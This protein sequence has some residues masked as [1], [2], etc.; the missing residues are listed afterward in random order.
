MEQTSTGEMRQDVLTGRWVIYAPDRSGRP[1]EMSP[2]AAES[3]ALP[4]KDATCPFCLGNETMIPP[5]VFELASAGDHGWRT[6][7]VPNKYPVLRPDANVA[8]VHRG[9]HRVTSSYGRHEVVIET[10]FHN[11]DIPVMTADE[12]ESIVE[13]YARRYHALYRDDESIETVIIF[14]NHGPRAGT[15]LH[16]PHSQI[17]AMGLVP[18]T[19][20][21]RERIALDYYERNHRCLVCD[22]VQYERTDRTRLVYEDA[23]FLSFVPFAAEAPF[24]MCIMPKW[25]SADFGSIAPERQRELAAVLQD[26]LR[27][28]HDTLDDPD[29]NYVIHSG[30]R[31]DRAGPHL[32]WYLQIRPRLTTPAGFEIGSGMAV[33]HSLP[34]RDAERLRRR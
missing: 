8:G 30:C 24:E 7:V 23:S 22:V 3:G 17:I 15:S 25:H 13:T 16:H 18:E 5:I 33:N 19:V 10:P 28:L 4:E 31:Q 11:R 29:Y 9:V 2:A 26:A 27:R 32:H 14:R 6:R 1:N 21:R 20:A 34:E 12:V